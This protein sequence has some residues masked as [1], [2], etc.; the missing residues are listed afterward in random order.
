MSKVTVRIRDGISNVLIDEQLLYLS[1]HNSNKCFCS[2]KPIYF[3]CS[4]SLWGSEDLPTHS[5]KDEI[6]LILFLSC[7]LCSS[8]KTIMSLLHSSSSSSAFSSSTFLFT[9]TSPLSFSCCC[10]LFAFILFHLL[11]SHHLGDANLPVKSLS[12]FL[13]HKSP[14]TSPLFLFPPSISPLL[15]FAYTF[16]IFPCSL[17]KLHPLFLLLVKTSPWHFS[18]WS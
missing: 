16:I 1:S 13:Q 7:S 17:I 11:H 12:S 5:V 18:G 2:M 9:F 8:F 6:T 4:T 15:S 10:Y 3:T 14:S